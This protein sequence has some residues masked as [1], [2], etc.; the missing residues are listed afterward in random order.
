VLMFLGNWDAF[1]GF[2]GWTTAYFI[3]LVAWLQCGI[4]VTGAIGEIGVAGGKSFAMAFTRRP[5]EA[6]VACDLFSTGIERDNV[7]DANLP[8]FLDLLDTLQIPKDDVRILKQ[9]SLQLND[10][11]LVNLYCGPKFGGPKV[12]GFRL[13]HVDGG[14]YAEAAFN[15]L[16]AAAC[17][18]VPGGVVLVDDLHN[19]GFP[20]VQEGFHRYM[21]ANPPPR[22]LVPFLYTGRLF[23]TTPGYASVYMH[24][25]QRAHKGAR[26][27]E[28]YG[29][30]ILTTPADQVR[31]SETDFETMLRGQRPTAGRKAAEFPAR[32]NAAQGLP[33]RSI[34][35]NE[36]S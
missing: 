31:I 9:S 1:P 25:I 29:V 18:L 19:F 26:Q 10:A 27:E 16:N 15:D 2:I 36:P 32:A 21:L 28:L 20:G 11:D 30:K 33:T 13:F 14:H 24:A 4:G 12:G 3:H 6:L 35:Y 7:P 17:A 5:G 23:L 8:M 22:R 34:V